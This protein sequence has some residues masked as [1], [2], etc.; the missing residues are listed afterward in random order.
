MNSHIKIPKDKIDAFCQ[1]HHISDMG[2]F[3][4]VLH[5]N[6]HANSGIGVLISFEERHRPEPAKIGEIRDEL[7]K[8][9]GQN[10]ELMERQAVEKNQ[11]PVRRRHI[12]K[13]VESIYSA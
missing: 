5:E 3:G 7:A 4:T 11:N 9:F 2:L 1:E 6:F 10:V 13:S 12:L 8:I